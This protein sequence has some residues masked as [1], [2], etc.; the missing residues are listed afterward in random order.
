MKAYKILNVKEVMAHILMKDTF[1]EFLVSEVKIL[2]KANLFLTGKPAEGF[3]PEEA[4]DESGYVAYKELRSICFD[5]IKGEKTPDSFT[6][7]FL[8][9]RSE[10]ENLIEDCDS[11]L[12]PQDVE[13]LSVLVRFKD[14]ELSFTTGSALRIFTMDK[15]LNMAWDQWLERFMDKCGILWDALA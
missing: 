1:D 2:G 9:K 3:F 14:G 11:T 6:F 15:S 8:L 5:M 13:S 10:V 4:L 7:M 12:Q